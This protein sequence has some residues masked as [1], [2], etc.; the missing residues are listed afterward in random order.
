MQ[1]IVEPEILDHLPP[2]DPA[3]I[4]SRRDL[5]R[6]NWFMRN[7]PLLARVLCEH[8]PEPPKSIVDLGSGDGTMALALARKTGWRAVKIQ[9]LDLQP[10]IG[11]ETLQ[12][13][14][15]LGWEAEVIATNLHDWIRDAPRCDLLL[16]NLF[17]HH[18]EEKQLRP[19]FQGFA[20]T[21]HAMVS[22]DPRRWL[23]A[24]LAT[25]FLWMLG[26]NRVTRHDARV[27]VR[28]GF[29][30]RELSALWPDKSGFELAEFPGGYASHLFMATSLT[31]DS[32]NRKSDSQRIRSV[33]HVI[34]PLDPPGSSESID[35]MKSRATGQT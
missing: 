31:L 26:C 14:H 29:R 25:R 6:I 19:I 5:R 16:A 15:A 17:L 1:R 18:F 20:S 21:C 12:A 32:F 7:V 4:H 3:A 24:L 2:D 23:P 8:L 11:P 22:C 13:F 9:L 33:Q 30:D 28:G 10:V 27:S 34:R 35:K